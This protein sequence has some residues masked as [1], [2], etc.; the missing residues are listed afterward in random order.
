MSYLVIARK[1]RP[2]E[3][4]EVVGQQHITRT[5]KNA[6]KFDK[7]SHA[8]L[9]TGPRGI[10][11]TTTARIFAKAVNCKNRKAEEPCNNC[12]TCREITNSGSVDVIEID[13]ASNRGID[14]IRRLRENI[15]F[16]P[17]NAK[18]KVY[19]IDEVHMLTKEAFNAILK[20]LE[21]PPSHAIFIMAT[22]EPE[23][24]LDTITSRCQKFNFKLIPEILIK[25]TL[26]DIAEKENIKYE[27]DGLTM[28][29]RAGGGSMR[30]AESIMDQAVSY[31]EGRVVAEDISELLGLIPRDVLFSYT[32]FIKNREVKK[33]LELTHDLLKK[34]HNLNHLF[35][36]LLMHFRNLMYAKV[37]GKATGFLGFNKDYSEKLS[38]AAEDFSKEQLV[39]ITEFLTKN[40]QRMKYS[41][42]IHIVM[43]TII[44]K[45]CQ[46]YVSFDDILNMVEQEK[47]E[48][49]DYMPEIKSETKPKK[50]GRWEKITDLIKKES[51][52]LYHS[53]KEA[54]ASLKGKE[55]L[56]TYNGSLDL[57]ERH[58]QILKSKIKEVMGEE[59]Y[60]KI[61][62]QPKEAETDNIK[63][64]KEFVSLTRIEEEEPIVGGIVDLFGGRIEKK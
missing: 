42:N 48:I 54:K 26:Q 63:P 38:D 19:I 62:K 17:S 21:E 33:A 13:A 12:V 23:K 25:E 10:G 50:G 36:D 11:K 46:R 32:E 56:I 5:L 9:F 27:E 59:Y 22:T 52:P 6:I 37:F 61:L 49:E 51:Q 8:Y 41:E 57:T 64:K 20:T 1:Y 18:Y 44:F 7:I 34:G 14:E 28:I 2:Q 30:D 24:V 55:I 45:L 3:F 35:N 39:W 16:A 53:L 60:P 47:P 58:N 43:D 29:A 31:S 15:K 40:S 4:G